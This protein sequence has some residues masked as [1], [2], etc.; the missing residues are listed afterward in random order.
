VDLAAAICGCSADDR[1]DFRVQEAFRVV[2]EDEAD[3][4][5]EECSSSSIT[6]VCLWQVLDSWGAEQKRAFVK[7][8]TGTDR[9]AAAAHSAVGPCGVHSSLECGAI[10]ADELLSPEDCVSRPKY[11]TSL[12]DALSRMQVASTPRQ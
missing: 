9:W 12:T 10:Q 7:F 11:G 8:V 4:D 6:L 5:T 1:T 3:P 2:L